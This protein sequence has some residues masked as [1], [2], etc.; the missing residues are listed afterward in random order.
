MGERSRYH[1]SSVADMRICQ[2][3]RSS[4]PLRAAVNNRIPHSSKTLSRD[5]VRSRDHDLATR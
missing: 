3:C 5:R 1:P 4:L 2:F